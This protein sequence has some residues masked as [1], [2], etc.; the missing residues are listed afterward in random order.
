MRN[1]DTECKKTLL[2]FAKTFRDECDS[3][4][5]DN[6]LPKHEL[7]M[8][9]RKG[10]WSKKTNSDFE[11]CIGEMAKVADYKKITNSFHHMVRYGIRIPELDQCIISFGFYYREQINSKP[12]ISPVSLC[13]EFFNFF[14]S[15]KVTHKY[16]VRLSHFES[17]ILSGQFG[18]H[19]VLRKKSKPPLNYGDSFDSLESNDMLQRMFMS[20]F[21]I[22]LTVSHDSYFDKGNNPEFEKVFKTDFGT[23]NSGEFDRQINREIDALLI[24]LRIHK[25]SGVFK[26]NYIIRDCVGYHPQRVS[27]RTSSNFTNIFVSGN[28]FN[29]T[30]KELP[31]IRKYFF[32]VREILNNDDDPKEFQGLRIATNRLCEGI[33]RRNVSDQVIDFMIGLEALYLPDTSSELSYRLSLRVAKTLE[34]N[35]GKVSDLFDFVRRMYGQRSGIA[36]GRED[37]VT[38]EEVKKLEDVLRMSIKRYIKTPTNFTGEKLNKIVL[39]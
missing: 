9:M 32:K 11:K 3:I 30:K 13:D 39:L 10:H 4:S 29:L 21:V 34:K 37:S 38:P 18:D 8:K 1:I 7:F 31:T 25:N 5:R 24:A 17:E 2:R 16:T 14:N 27:S 28:S 15:S 6:K 20:D 35:S 23:I 19:L 33:Q 12:R 26:E 36:H 22:E